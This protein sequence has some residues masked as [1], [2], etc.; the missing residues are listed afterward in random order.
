MGLRILQAASLGVVNPK[1]VVA[2][3]A[4]VDLNLANAPVIA[5]SFSGHGSEDDGLQRAL[6]RIKEN[7]GITPFCRQAWWDC[8]GHT[9]Y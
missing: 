7:V 6:V 5:R 1:S 9:V 4:V 2:P 8:V 3:V